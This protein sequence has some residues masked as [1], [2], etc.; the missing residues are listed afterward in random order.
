MV[1][2][3]AL[4]VMEVVEVMVVLAQLLPQLLLL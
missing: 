1:V 3:M 4:V 2:E